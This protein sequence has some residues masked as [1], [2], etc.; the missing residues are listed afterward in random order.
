M[1]CCSVFKIIFIRINRD[2]LLKNWVNLV[3]ILK[4]LVNV[5]MIVMKVKKKEFGKVICDMI[6]LIYLV[7][8]LF[9]L[10]FGMK[11]LFFFIFLVIWVGLMVIVV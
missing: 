9:G 11:L 6:L 10:I 4:I 2:V 8:F 3:F 5:G 7:V 1:I